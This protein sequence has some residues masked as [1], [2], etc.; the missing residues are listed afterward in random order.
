MRLPL[1]LTIDGS[2]QGKVG[3]EWSSAEQNFLQQRKI[4]NTDNTTQHGGNMSII[5]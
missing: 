2:G 5:Q 1:P 3:G 4:I